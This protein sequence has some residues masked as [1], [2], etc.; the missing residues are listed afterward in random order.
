[1]PKAGNVNPEGFIAGDLKE[2]DYAEKVEETVA[3]IQGD[4]I[5]SQGVKAD[6]NELI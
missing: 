3:N 4:T 1:L 6:K 5:F 2:P